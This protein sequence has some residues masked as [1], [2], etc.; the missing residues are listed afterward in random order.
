M[1]KAWDFWKIG[2]SPAH[3]TGP[4]ADSPEDISSLGV[5]CASNEQ[6]ASRCEWAVRGFLG[7]VEVSVLPEEFTEPAV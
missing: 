5:P 6:P 7:K 1:T 2:L 4:S 3:F